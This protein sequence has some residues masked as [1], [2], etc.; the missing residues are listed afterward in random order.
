MRWRCCAGRGPAPYQGIPR[1]ALGGEPIAAGQLLIYQ[2]LSETAAAYATEDDYLD[3]GLRVLRHSHR[4]CTLP[5]VP[6][7]RTIP[8]MPDT[9]IGNLPPGGMLIASR[10]RVGRWVRLCR[11]RSRR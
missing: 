4:G 6:T 3:A 11:L 7:R 2:A 1:A 9:R 10:R 8:M 5:A